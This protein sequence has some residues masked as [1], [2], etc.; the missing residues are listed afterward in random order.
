MSIKIL[1][2][3]IIFV[4][5]F[6]AGFGFGSSAR[7]QDTATTTPETAILPSEGS[8]AS[9]TPETVATS[10]PEQVIPE[11]PVATTTPEQ[12]EPPAPEPDATT[13]PLQAVEEPETGE[14]AAT[15]GE[16]VDPSTPS[17]SA[18]A[19]GDSAQDDGIATPSSPEPQAPLPPLTQDEPAPTFDPAIAPSDVTISVLMPDGTP[20]PFP[21]FVTYVGVGNKNYGGRI[22]ANGSLTV[23]MPQGRYYT[24]LLILSTDYVLHG[25][26]PSFFLEANEER[27]FGALQLVPKTQDV[28]R[29]LADSTLEENLVREAGTPGG[30]AKI[31][32]LIVK[33]L[34]QILEEVRALAQR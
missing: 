26:G 13:A 30:M 22:D 11:E 27:D 25:D 7:A 8:I 24:E 5:V 19:T 34:M 32:L 33:L 29:P 17:P 6:I 12:G 28:S 31:L 3:A 10:T 21:V 18:D 15:T 2:T 23:T 1:P 4:T 9:S 16:A 20:P 14:E